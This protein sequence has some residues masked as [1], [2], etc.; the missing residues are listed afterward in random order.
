MKHPPY[1][2]TAN[3]DYHS[4]EFVSEGPKGRIPKSVIFAKV[5]G[6]LYNL[7]FGDWDNANQHLNDTARSNNGDRDYVF[8]TVATTVVNFLEKFPDAL[9]FFEGSTSS[10][11]RLYQIELGRNL[12]EINQNFELFG[13]ANNH[14][15]TF[16]RGRQYEAF[17]I[18]KREYCTF[19]SLK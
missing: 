7:G 15:E 8:A 19:D 1:P 5:A 11:T 18:K 12:M 2:I 16:E 17:L 4:F 6:S 10:R 3:D 9:V 13:Y 14:W